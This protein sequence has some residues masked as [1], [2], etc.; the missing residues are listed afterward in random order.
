MSVI[1]KIRFVNAMDMHVSQPIK[2]FFDSSIMQLFINDVMYK[3]IEWNS[4]SPKG[5]WSRILEHPYTGIGLRC[6]KIPVK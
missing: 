3:K 4:L 2:M 5:P 6:W 1:Y